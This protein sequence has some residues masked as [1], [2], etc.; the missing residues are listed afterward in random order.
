LGDLLDVN[1][2]CDSNS[3]TGNTFKTA[4]QTCIQ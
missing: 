2:G 3:W 4:N 1:P